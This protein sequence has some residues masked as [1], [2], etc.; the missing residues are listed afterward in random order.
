MDHNVYEL[1]ARDHKLNL[2]LLWICEVVYKRFKSMRLPHFLKEFRLESGRSFHLIDCHLLE[3]IKSGEDY[4]VAALEQ[5][6]G[7]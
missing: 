7:C 4:V 5:T 1:H 2:E 6:D 3:V